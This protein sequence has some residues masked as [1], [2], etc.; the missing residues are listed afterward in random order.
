MSW[1]SQ[2]LFGAPHLQA[3]L[4]PEQTGGLRGSQHKS[5]EEVYREGDQEGLHGTV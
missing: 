2:A 1:L 4:A 5:W 3:P